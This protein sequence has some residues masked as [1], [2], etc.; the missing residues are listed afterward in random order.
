MKK[1]LGFLCLPQSQDVNINNIC[2]VGSLAAQIAR[3]EV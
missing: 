2:I 3:G 1:K